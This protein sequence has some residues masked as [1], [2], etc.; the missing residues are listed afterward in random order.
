MQN[1]EQL[2]KYQ[3]QLLTFIDKE[4][5]KLNGN[6]QLL[7]RARLERAIAKLYI[8]IKDAGTDT[9]RIDDLNGKLEPAKKLKELSGKPDRQPSDEEDIAKL[10]NRI[11]GCEAEDLEG[12]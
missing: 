12:L 5:D 6:K 3:R 9:L 4:E 8:A 7:A 2:Q 11:H 1:L 10:K